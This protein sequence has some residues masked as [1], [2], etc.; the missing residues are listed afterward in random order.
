M[1]WHFSILLLYSL[2]RSEWFRT[3]TLAPHRTQPQLKEVLA[4]ECFA[5]KVPSLEDDLESQKTYVRLRPKR[6]NRRSLETRW[7]GFGF[8]TLVTDCVVTA[9]FQSDQDAYESKCKNEMEVFGQPS[10][11]DPSHP[12]SGTPQGET[13]W[14]VAVSHWG[15]EERSTR[16]LEY[17]RSKPMR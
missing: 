14:E 12:A 6:M 8:Q 11:L 15:M 5:A 3:C 13:S 4:R 1:Y 16:K 9:I 7:G 17:Q 10:H 2:L